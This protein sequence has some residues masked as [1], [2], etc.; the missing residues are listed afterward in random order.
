MSRPFWIWFVSI[1]S[2]IYFI[3][4]LGGTIMSAYSY[5]RYG[6][7]Y[8][9]ALAAMDKS[10]AQFETMQADFNKKLEGM[11]PEMR[12]RM[13]MPNFVIRGSFVLESW[14]PAVSASEYIERNLWI[15]KGSPCL[16]MRSWL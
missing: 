16:P 1:L 10:A 4:G 12:Q 6:G 9:Q 7:P 14:G 5:A 8:A 3:T 11:P 15:M 2:I 13:N